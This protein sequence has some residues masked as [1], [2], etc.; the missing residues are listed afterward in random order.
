MAET[1]TAATICRAGNSPMPCQPAAS[2]TGEPELKRPKLR[3][4]PFADGITRP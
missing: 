2:A 3:V 1:R 4:P